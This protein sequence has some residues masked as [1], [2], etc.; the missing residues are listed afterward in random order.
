MFIIL[1][2]KC[3]STQTFSI[4]LL[5]FLIVHKHFHFNFIYLFLFLFAFLQKNG[6]S[7]CFSIWDWNVNWVMNTLEIDDCFEIQ[8]KFGLRLIRSFFFLFMKF[9]THL[10]F[11]FF[12]WKSLLY[13]Y[14]FVIWIDSIWILILFDFF[15]IFIFIVYFILTQDWLYVFWLE[16]YGMLGG[17]WL[18]KKI[19]ISVYSVFCVSF[20]FFMFVHFFQFSAFLFS[21]LP[22]PVFLLKRS[23]QYSFTMQQG[24]KTWK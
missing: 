12:N 23:E 19:I 16:F 18:S 14:L 1:S 21:L 11:A 4:A 17:C 22:L 6:F 8:L 20:L 24:L 3:N 2:K 5:K 7:L 13:C 10:T 15:E 9:H